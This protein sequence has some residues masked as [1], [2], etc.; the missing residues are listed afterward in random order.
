MA[1]RRRPG[2]TLIELLVVIAIIGVLTALLLPAV[3]Q[4]RESARRV[5]CRN[6]LKQMGLALLNYHDAH[7]LF[8]PGSVISSTACDLSTGAR[9][10]APWSVLVLP[11]LD[12]LSRYDQFDFDGS[13]A[14]IA[15]ESTNVNEPF[16]IVPNAKFQCPSDSNSKRSEPNANY[17]GVQ[18]GGTD[19]EALCRVGTASNYRVRYDNGILYLNSSIALGDIADGTSKTLLV[20]ESR[21]WFAVGQN[22]PYGT[23]FTWAST[24]RNA[25]T[26]SHVNMVASAT[27]PINQPQ[28]DYDPSKGPYT[29][30]PA[31]IGTIVGT[32]TRSFGSWHLGGSH[33]TF[34]DGGVRFISEAVDTTIYRR[35]GQRADGLVTENLY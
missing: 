16:Q 12:E 34:A 8:P 23:Y 1:N 2:F 30:H 17:R 9:R 24:T 25:G 11:Y 15:N 5:Q 14:S 18:G 3:Q 28:F 13:F 26:S 6:K 4:A 27:D 10:G 31:G 35:A 33:F 32:H 20:G 19:S 29:A 7:S 21:W 22:S